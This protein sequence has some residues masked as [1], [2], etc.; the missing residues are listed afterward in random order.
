MI[1]SQ[2][3]IQIPQLTGTEVEWELRHGALILDTRETKQFAS[4]HIS[5]ALQ[6]GLLGSFASWAAVLI[7][8]SQ[9][10]VLVT[11]SGNR[12]QEA[13]NRLARVGLKEVVG[14]TLADKKRWQQDGIK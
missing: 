9:K 6:I 11:D 5:G 14:Y 12:A 4:F 13:Q 1:Y 8:P 7:E 2:K 3:L 10:L